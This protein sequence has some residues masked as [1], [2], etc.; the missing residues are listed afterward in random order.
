M[1]AP[2]AVRAA[3]MHT[4]AYL[5]IGMLDSLTGV[6]GADK[7]SLRSDLGAPEVRS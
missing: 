1:A 3:A 5:I 4:R 6:R 7:V 2:K